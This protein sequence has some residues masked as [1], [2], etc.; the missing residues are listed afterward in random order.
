MRRL[1]KSSFLTVGILLAVGC[2]KPD[3][4]VPGDI[5]SSLSLANSLQ[6]SG[7]SVSRKIINDT[8][9]LSGFLDSLRSDL[10][11]GRMAFF[12]SHIEDPFDGGEKFQC[13]SFECR[14]RTDSAFSKSTAQLLSWN[15]R[16]SK[17]VIDTTINE[18]SPQWEVFGPFPGRGE[19]VFGPRPSRDDAEDEPGNPTSKQFS[20]FVGTPDQPFYASIGGDSLGVLGVDSVR[21]LEEKGGL[22]PDEFHSGKIRVEWMQ[23]ETPDGRRGWTRGASLRDW[24][25]PFA[26]LRID[27]LTTGWRIAGLFSSEEER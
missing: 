7:S 22:I 15:F 16:W 13:D 18:T 20:V 4:T 11:R 9:G 25:G 6:E 8:D 3:P 21:R 24:E 26:I 19:I 23:V 5:R 10:Q 12:L 14:L 27:H 17:M 2:R 1:S